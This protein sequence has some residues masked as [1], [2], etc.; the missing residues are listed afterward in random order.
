MF[1]AFEDTE[2]PSKFRAFFKSDLMDMFL[3]ATIAYF[4]AF[5]N[6]RRSAAAAKAN[7]EDVRTALHACTVA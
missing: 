6:E 3:H 1:R 2:T 4:V 7:A 5:F